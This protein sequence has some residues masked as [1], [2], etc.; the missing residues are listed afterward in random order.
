MFHELAARPWVWPLP[1][2]AIASA[3]LV[4]WFL[5]R[6]RERAAF[7]ASSAFIASLLL[8][9]AA[10]LYPVL[11]P[12]CL[13]PELAIDAHLAATGPTAL[14]FGLYWWVPA[15]TLGIVYFVGLFRSMRGKVKPGAYH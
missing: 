5:H 1:L 10:V 3:A 4:L 14:A 8:A 11:L 7:L 13:D 15:V 6:G 9:T 2:V 12:S